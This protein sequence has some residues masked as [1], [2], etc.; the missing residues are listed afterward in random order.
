MYHNG[1][2]ESIIGEWMKLRDVREEVVLATKY[3]SAWRLTEQD[4]KIQ[5]NYGGNN[6]KSM[7]AA[8]YSS[9]EKL[10]TKYVDVVRRRS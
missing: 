9:L 4:T 10:Q 2:S 5:S 3:S 8:F 7:R 1:E 6:K